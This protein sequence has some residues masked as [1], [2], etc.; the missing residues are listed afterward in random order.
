MFGV[1]AKILAWTM[2]SQCIKAR[3]SNMAVYTEAP[4]SCGSSGIKILFCDVLLYMKPSADVVVDVLPLQCSMLLKANI[5][6][7]MPS[8][9]VG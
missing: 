7:Q 2:M 6:T 5:V 1:D 9:W 3:H 4:V 8:K